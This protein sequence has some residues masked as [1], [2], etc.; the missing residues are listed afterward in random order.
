VVKIIFSW[1]LLNN[2]GRAAH[3][4]AKYPQGEGL[5]GS[6][7]FLKKP[8]GRF[9]FFLRWYRWQVGVRCQRP[10]R[11]LNAECPTT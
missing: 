8:S 10:S 5:S 9:P 4:P 2:S 11:V 7:S 3:R 6:T 1:R